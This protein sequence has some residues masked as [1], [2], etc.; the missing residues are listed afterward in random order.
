[1]REAA[2]LYQ[3]ILMAL[4]PPA[5]LVTTCSNTL[6]ISTRATGDISTIVTAGSSE[7]STA[8]NSRSGRCNN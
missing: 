3:A 6:G 7:P 4:Q 1:M 5:D 2:S 8:N